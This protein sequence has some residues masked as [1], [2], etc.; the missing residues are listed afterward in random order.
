MEKLEHFRHILLFE[1]NREA[2]AAVAA[3]N[4]CAACG[5]N[6][7]RERDRTARKWFSRF[8]KDHSHIRDT[9]RS[10]ELTGFD[11]DSL[12]TLIHNDPRQCTREL[13]NVKNCATF[14]F[15]GKG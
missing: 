7:I 14:A 5:Y 8:K 2:K 11:E 4:I 10:G 13:A 1:F 12:N 6:A 3:R 9:P 15:N